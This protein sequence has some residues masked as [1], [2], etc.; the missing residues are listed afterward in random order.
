MSSYDGQDFTPVVIRK[1]AAQKKQEGVFMPKTQ[2]KRHDAGKNS[3]NAPPP[4]KHKD[5]SDG[6]DAP[7]KAKKEVNP[8]LKDQILA[9]RKEK[10]WTQKVL[11]EKSSVA[12]AIVSDIEKGEMP[13]SVNLAKIGRALGQVFKKI[14]SNK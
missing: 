6:F 1:T 12:L 7:V 9:A 10:G 14:K 4:P 8:D 11:A 3:Q 2:I 5:D 13:S